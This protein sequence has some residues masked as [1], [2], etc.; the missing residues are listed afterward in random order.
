MT[1]AV[2]AGGKGGSGYRS[3]HVRRFKIF[4]FSIFSCK[5]KLGL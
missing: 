4:L 3:C 5:E 2:A 1:G